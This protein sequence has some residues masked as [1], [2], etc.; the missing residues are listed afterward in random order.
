MK[1]NYRDKMILVCLAA[2][3]VLVCVG[4]LL[5]KPKYQEIQD[6]NETLKTTQETWNG[7]KAKIDQIDP[8]KDE[9]KTTYKSSSE[10]ADDFADVTLVDT[11]EELDEY[12]Q[13]T[14]DDCKIE[15]KSVDLSSPATA[16]LGYYFFTPSTLS[17]SMLD[18][19][20]INGS[21]AEETAKLLEESKALSERTKE[22]VIRTQYGISGKAKKE[23]VWKFMESIKKFDTTML[24][25]SVNISD[26]SFGEDAKAK[27]PSKADDKSDVSFVISIYSVFPM[28]EPNV[29]A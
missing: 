16:D 6:N 14:A 11:P 15:I 17:S 19:A 27:D 3:L 24:I 23:D 20:D 26:Y 25:N 1:L 13:K 18:A 29:E 9:I 2:V 28:D 22:T 5:I 4:F 10:L 21:Y 7:I 8:L 12:F